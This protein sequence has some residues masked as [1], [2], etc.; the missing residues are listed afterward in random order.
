[1]QLPR[2]SGEIEAIQAPKEK[3]DTCS[4]SV[5]N[6]VRLIDLTVPQQQFSVCK[7]GISEDWIKIIK[8]LFSV[9]SCRPPR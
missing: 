3:C 5:F 9:M 6:K 8:I 1:M 4:V 2:L 7:M